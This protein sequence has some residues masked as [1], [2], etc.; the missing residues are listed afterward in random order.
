[1]LEAQ[2][3]GG[4]WKD[5]RLAGRQTAKAVL[6]GLDATGTLLGRSILEADHVIFWRNILYV[7]TYPE[8][9]WNGLYGRGN[10]RAAVW[11]LLVAFS[12]IYC[13]K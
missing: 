10:F 7:W 1:M 12:R 4:F 2:I 11:E 13:E 3:T 5:K 6:T 9:L 8:T